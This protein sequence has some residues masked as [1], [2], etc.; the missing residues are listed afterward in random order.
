[1]PQKFGKNVSSEWVEGEIRLAGTLDGRMIA[2]LTAIA[3]TGSINRAAKQVGLS[4][5][6]AWQIIERA[7]N[8]APKVLVST[9]TGGSKGGG[10]HLTDA[11]HALLKLFTRLEKQHKQFL[12]ELNQS[13]IADPD[14]LLLLQ[15]LVVKTSARNQLFGNIS[16]IQIGKVH[17]EVT[18]TLKG[19]EKIN[20][21]V[22]LTAIES[23]GLSVGL[24]A[25]LLINDSDITLT[26][27]ADHER[28]IA[29]N[30]L[31]CRVL[32][33][34][35]DGLNAEVKVL[36]PGGEILAVTMTEH[37]V[38]DMGIEPGQALWAI[39]SNNAA[40][41][42]ARLQF[43]DTAHIKSGETTTEASN[44]TEVQRR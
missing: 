18:L 23:T 31:P 25:L 39:F 15:R 6:G 26:T 36:L 37:S 3:Q 32:R 38:E 8:G 14:T 29:S 44:Q 33:I 24:D 20:V 11:G 16:A 43:P 30:H 40:I 42:G 28:F 1:M 35:Q 5:K 22:P 4:Y 34:Q 2:L 27:E 17:A 9:A 19:G 7:N 41:L 21:T 13:L 12:A 10:T